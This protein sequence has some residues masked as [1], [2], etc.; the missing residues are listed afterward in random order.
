MLLLGALRASGSNLLKRIA[1][2]MFVVDFGWVFCSQKMAER[3]LSVLLREEEIGRVLDPV[4]KSYGFLGS[5]ILFL[6]AFSFPEETQLRR[7]TES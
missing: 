4:R 2:F 6:L 1:K 5:A 7:S 3:T